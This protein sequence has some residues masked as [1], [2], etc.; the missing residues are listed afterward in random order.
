M[1]DTIV[2]LATPNGES[3][4]SLI[5]VS[6]EKALEIASKMEK[7]NVNLGNTACKV[8]EAKTYIEKV[9]KMG[10][11]GKKKKKARC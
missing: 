6:G 4:L 10:R 7:V 3:A 5:R 2:A 9:V 8:P 1:T 11:L